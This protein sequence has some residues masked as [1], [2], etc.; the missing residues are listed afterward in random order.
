MK[1][2]LTVIVLGACMCVSY[3]LL[4]YRLD[5]LSYWGDEVG[6]ILYARNDFLPMIRVL[7]KEDVH[8]PLYY[9]V[10]HWWM[11]FFGEGEYALRFLS[12]I[13]ALLSLIA[14]Y[15]LAEK[16]FNRT[17]AVLTVVLMALSPECLIFGR[18]VR[19]YSWALLCATCATYFFVRFLQDGSRASVAWYVVSATILLYMTYTPLSVLIAHN[20]ILLCGIREYRGMIKRWVIGQIAV[21]LLYLPCIIL[22]I[23]MMLR[24]A[25]EGLPPSDFS[26]GLSGVVMKIGYSLYA[27]GFGET[28]FPW[29][30][31]AVIP[32]GIVLV[33]A[34]F[35]ASVRM[36]RQVFA[37]LVLLGV[38][39]LFTTAILSTVKTS[40]SF[41]YTP[42]RTLFALPYFYLLIAYGIDS[43]RPAWLKWG[44]AGVLVV[45]SSIAISNYFRGKDYIMPTYLA[46]W[47]GV[48][49]EVQQAAAPD[50]VVVGEET[51][52]FDY[53][54]NREGYRFRFCIEEGEAQRHLAAHPSA[55]VFYIKTGRDHQPS[56]LSE[57][58]AGWV[59][60]NYRLVS[61]K[62]YAATD[63]TYARFKKLLLKRE[64]YRYKM[65]LLEFEK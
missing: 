11:V 40:S 56:G 19:Y 10:L 22:F 42:S 5:L 15:A 64:P 8:P 65:E 32:A 51:R 29:R 60:D 53:Y 13:P 28:L 41:L 52:E 3:L 35:R 34:L 43:M 46:P 55:R 27:F 47:N 37:V 4:S 6:S 48:L 17:V 24:M 12:L 2:Y 25:Q 20:V 18:M 36:N 21:G 49:R 54:Y 31:W 45:V 61:R 62:G 16:L 26:R 58:F 44:A 50:D 14:V 63:E 23:M 9:C 7:L 33:C 57:E 38:P 39:L 59:Q 1:K 30:L